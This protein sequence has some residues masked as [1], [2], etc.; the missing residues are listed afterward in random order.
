MY[1]PDLL[2]DFVRSAGF[3]IVKFDVDEYT[4]RPPQQGIPKVH[5]RI[6]GKKLNTKPFS[7]IKL[8]PKNYIKTL[9]SINKYYIYLQYLL[10]SR[11]L[12]K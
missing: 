12:K 9:L 7:E 5:I 11:L 3:E 8:T 10:Y 2:K 4:K 6:I 1:T